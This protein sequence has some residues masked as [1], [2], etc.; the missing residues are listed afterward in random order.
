MFRGNF[1]KKWGEKVDKEIGIGDSYKDVL[2]HLRRLSFLW[3]MSHFVYCTTQFHM[4]LLQKSCEM[5]HFHS[6]YS[7]V[8]SLQLAMNLCLVLFL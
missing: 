2:R 4:L 7:V 8:V 5:D 3:F 6:L 1:L